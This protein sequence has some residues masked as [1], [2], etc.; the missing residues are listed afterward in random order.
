MRE[1]KREREIERER[2]EKGKIRREVIIIICGIE[3]KS[4]GIKFQKSKKVSLFSY[5]DE[6]MIILDSI[7]NNNFL[8]NIQFMHRSL[9]MI[10]RG[11]C[12]S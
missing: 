2:E 8:Y 1:M 12:L 4:E 7:A 11:I 6:F 3:R 10:L 5:V 9:I